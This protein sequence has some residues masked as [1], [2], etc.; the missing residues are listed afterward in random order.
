MTSAAVR[1]LKRTNPKT[2]VSITFVKRSDHSDCIPFLLPVRYSRAES[3]KVLKAF[4]DRILVCQRRNYC[5]DR[6]SWVRGM[7]SIS[8]T[9]SVLSFG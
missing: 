6:L 4:A 7:V 1:C 3:R 2:L 8:S 5:M 9:T